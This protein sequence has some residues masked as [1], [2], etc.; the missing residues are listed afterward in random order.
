MILPEM[1]LGDGKLIQEPMSSERGSSGR[2][3]PDDHSAETGSTGRHLQSVFRIKVSGQK[4]EHVYHTRRAHKKSRGG[5][6]TCKKR[7]IK[8]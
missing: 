6:L 7:R 2:T 4:Q 5:C 1:K 3:P 8:V